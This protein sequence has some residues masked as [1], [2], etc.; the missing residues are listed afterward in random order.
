MNRYNECSSKSPKVVRKIRECIKGKI[1]EE[2]RVGSWRSAK[3][4]GARPSEGHSGEIYLSSLYRV[5]VKLRFLAFIPHAYRSKYSKFHSRMFNLK[6]IKKY[7]FFSL[8]LSSY[9]W[10]NLDKRAHIF[11]LIARDV[12]K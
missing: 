8:L 6:I 1:C 3:S 11:D 12:F 4:T 9:P 7:L 5:H 10:G 2:E